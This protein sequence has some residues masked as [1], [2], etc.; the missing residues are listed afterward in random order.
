[1]LECGTLHER[2][3]NKIRNKPYISRTKTIASL[4][5]A[6]ILRKIPLCI[7]IAY[8]EL[9]LHCNILSTF[10]ETSFYFQSTFS[11]F[12]NVSFRGEEHQMP[13][14]EL[15]KLTFVRISATDSVALLSTLITLIQMKNKMFNCIYCTI[16]QKQ[17]RSLSTFFHVNN[18]CVVKRFLYQ[19]IYHTCITYC[20]LNLVFNTTHNYFCHRGRIQIRRL[21][22]L[23]TR[24]RVTSNNDFRK[25]SRNSLLEKGGGCF[26]CFCLKFLWI[27]A[28]ARSH[29]YTPDVCACHHCETST[30]L[31][32]KRKCGIVIWFVGRV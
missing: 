24:L 8:C 26:G 4:M 25:I 14:F 13:K 20:L 12:L 17:E 15:Q 22:F 7:E 32:N 28:R 27:F 21:K 31:L 18:W 6:L 3:W 29:K 1:M 9:L 2:S 23:M 19:Q 5:V 16:V 11:N 30:A 10:E